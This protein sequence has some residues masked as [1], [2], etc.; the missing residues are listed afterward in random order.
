MTFLYEYVCGNHRVWGA[1]AVKELRVR[2]VGDA[3]Q[4]AAAFVG[5]L[6][7]YAESSATDDEQR[8]RKARTVRLG[9]DKDAVLDRV[10]RLRIPVLSRKLISEAYD[11]A[12]T[13]EGR[14]RYGDPTTA[15][16]FT[17]G[18][19]E[20]ARDLPHADARVTVDRAAGKVLEL[21]F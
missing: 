20:L 14:D 1:S 11:R 3:N 19:T 16:G 6:H 17:G 8:I 7:A 15:W 12:A 4:R 13:P 18:L 21:I 2:H 5:E 9:D 10:F